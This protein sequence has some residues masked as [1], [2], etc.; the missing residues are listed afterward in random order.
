[1]MMV[2]VMGWPEFGWRGMVADVKVRQPGG[3][4]RRWRVAAHGVGDRV[5]EQLMARSGMDMKMAKTCYHSHSLLDPFPPGIGDADFDLEGYILL[6]EKLLN[7][8]PSSPLP[9]KELNFEELK[10][11]KSSIDDFPPLVILGG[12]YVIFSNHLFDANDDFTSS[13]DDSPPKADVPEENFKIYSN[14][15]FE[16]DEEYISSNVNPL[17]NEVLEDIESEDSYVSNLDEPVLSVTPLSDANE[18]E[19][20]EPGGD[21][22]EITAFLDMDVSTVIKV[23]YHD[24]E[25][26]KIFKKIDSMDSSLLFSYGVKN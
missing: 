24:S 14:P 23:G 17:C 4:G 20:F 9:S 26:D 10:M 16:F 13:D 18:D 8:E 12:N 19:C 15:L 2:V 3:G 11:I 6:L 1:M 21:I 22:D 5:I 7:D 25:R